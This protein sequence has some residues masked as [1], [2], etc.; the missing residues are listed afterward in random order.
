MAM[1]LISYSCCI[2]KKKKA[3]KFATLGRAEDK[4]CPCWLDVNVGLEIQSSA[5]LKV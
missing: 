4:K 5:P 1:D 3:E 2:K